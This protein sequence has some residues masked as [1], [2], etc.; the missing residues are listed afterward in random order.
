MV[1]EEFLVKCVGRII[2]N[3]FVILLIY[4]F[5]IPDEYLEVVIK[6]LAGCQGGTRTVRNIYCLHFT[7]LQ[8]ISI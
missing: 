6:Y 3:F 2:N 5:Q 1:G 7:M 8:G 4:T